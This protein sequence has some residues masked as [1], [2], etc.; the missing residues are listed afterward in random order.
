MT[1]SRLGTLQT[2]SLSAIELIVMLQALQE[3]NLE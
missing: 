1:G 2:Q 3:F